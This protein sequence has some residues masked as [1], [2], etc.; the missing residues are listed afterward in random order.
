MG[1]DGKSEIGYTIAVGGDTV[2]VE[3]RKEMGKESRGGQLFQ[4]ENRNPG[5]HLTQVQGRS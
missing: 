2:R 1:G 3:G 5:G 4:G